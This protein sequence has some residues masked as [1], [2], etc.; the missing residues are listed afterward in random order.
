[1]VVDD[2]DL[3]SRPVAPD[4]TDAPSVV[5]ANAV[6]FPPIAPQSLQPITGRRTQIVEPAGRIDRQEFHPRTW[7]NRRRQP[8]NGMAGEDRRSAFVGEAPDHGPT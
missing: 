6:L 1:M 3:P 2:L 7:L 5:D 4:E 8:A